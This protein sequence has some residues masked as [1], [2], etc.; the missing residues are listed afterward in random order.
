MNEDIRTSI[1]TVAF[2][3]LA[4]AA[5]FYVYEYSKDVE[6]TY[7]TR[8]FSVDGM[9]KI[10]A[11]PD[12]ATFT[13]TVVSEGGKNVA[14][15]QNM[16]TEK[17]NKV[18]EFLKGQGIEEKD[19]KTSQY[20]LNPRYSYS[21]CVSGTC[22]AP[23]ITGYV[24]NQTLSV[25][26]RDTSTVGD[27][28]SGMVQNGANQVSDVNFVVDDEDEAK[29]NAREDAIKNAREKAQ[30]LAKAGGFRVGDLISIYEDAGPGP[31]ADSM[32]GMEMSSV[33]QSAPK[34]QPGT[35][36]SEVHMT[37]TYEILY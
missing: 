21:P 20:N 27:L 31:I 37:L 22:P 16:N 14:E 18:T 19:L 2:G 29:N 8:T 13:V 4:I 24:L 11:T 28:L 5:L 17:M 1:K 33:K 36:T 9:G 32:G 35:N 3:L 25:K 7:P 6:K 26:V 23:A 30:V 10:D 12:I 15:V 34:V